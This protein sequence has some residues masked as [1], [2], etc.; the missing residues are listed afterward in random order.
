MRSFSHKGSLFYVAIKEIA[1]FLARSI[2]ASYCTPPKFN[3]VSPPSLM[4]IHTICLIGGTTLNCVLTFYT[5]DISYLLLV[6]RRSYLPLRRPSKQCRSISIVGATITTDNTSFSK[7]G[8]WIIKH[9]W[10]YKFSK[11]FVS[12]LV[13]AVAC[14]RHLILF[15]LAYDSALQ[16]Q[17]YNNGRSFTYY[18]FW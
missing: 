1:I 14:I 12:S 16:I 4:K 9:L 10:R 7:R 15:Y 2:S 6:A 17:Y 5:L 18:L 11:N 3:K 8:Q 13:G